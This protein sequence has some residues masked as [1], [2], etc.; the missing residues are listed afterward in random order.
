MYAN[1]DFPELLGEEKYDTCDELCKRA[2]KNVF[3]ANTQMI[4][5][6][7]EQHHYETELNALK[8]PKGH[9]LWRVIWLQ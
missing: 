2:R 7:I 4:T 6:D 5:L 1:W 3:T 9:C 8:R